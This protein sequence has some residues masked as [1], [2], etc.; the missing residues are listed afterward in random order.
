MNITQSVLP[1]R[2]L[3]TKSI[4]RE[5]RTKDSMEENKNKYNA[6][7]DS[8]HKT[9][10]IIEDLSV[11]AQV[12]KF[13][14]FSDE[15]SVLL[16]QLRNRRDLE[17][18]S[19]LMSES[20]ERVLEED[21][22][23]KVNQLIKSVDSSQG[24]G[25]QNL[26]THARKFFPDDSDLVLVLREILK[27]RKLNPKL[28]KR[29]MS[30]LSHLEATVDPR[31]LKAGINVA[32][33][34]R[35]FGR[36]LSLDPALVRESYRNFLENEKTELENYQDW[37]SI[38]GYQKRGAV[39]DF[40][41]GALLA[42]ID[43]QDP[44]CSMLEFGHLLGKLGQLKLLRS[45]DIIF[46]KSILKSPL[47]KSF[48]ESEKSWLLFMLCVL[49]Q[50]EYLDDF[51]SEVLGERI[52]MREHAKRSQLLQVIYR[53]CKKL[54]IELFVGLEERESMLERFEQLAA[55]AYRREMIEARRNEKIKRKKYKNK[56]N[57]KS[58]DFYSDDNTN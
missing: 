2:N 9:G 56:K 29:L 13:A 58:F 53:A 4:A 8:L 15:M 17:K 45:S 3:Y 14:Y 36:Y 46:I 32:L 23:P 57:K 5:R 30:L 44:S 49:Q 19:G 34:A 21:V 16:A 18:K 11:G 27:R 35:L 6:Q 48:N 20:F 52:L 47:V 25:I 33:K 26:L 22:V 24:A 31:R 55:V 42:D 41:E 12:Q 7:M 38:Y 10:E 37:I 43:S 40:M 28:R 51:L 50:P 39:V 54:P 1:A